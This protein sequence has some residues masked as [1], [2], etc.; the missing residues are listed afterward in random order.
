VT[1]ILTQIA[2]SLAC[3]ATLASFWQSRPITMHAVG[4]V[5][6]VL[7]IAY[8]LGAGLLPIIALYA[9]LLPVNVARLRAALR[10]R[11]A[12]ALPA[13]PAGCCFTA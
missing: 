7:F 6:N 11:T 3:L 4:L 5:A 12:C 9:I 10:D 1:P 8:G 13:F 2:G